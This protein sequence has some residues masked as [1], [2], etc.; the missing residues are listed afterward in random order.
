MGGTGGGGGAVI[1][2][3]PGASQKEEDINN[4]LQYTVYMNTQTGKL[5]Q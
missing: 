4:I 5:S 1:P 3:G 2:E